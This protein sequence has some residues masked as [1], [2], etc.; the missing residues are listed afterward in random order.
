MRTISRREALRRV[1][2]AAALLSASPALANSYGPPRAPI[3]I[4]M[5]S[6][7][8]QWRAARQ[9]RHG[10]KFHDAPTFLE[11]AWFLGASGVQ[12]AIE[13]HDRAHARRI[14]YLANKFEM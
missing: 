6:Y 3:G 12:V 9:N 13:N 5:H 14:K 10:A 7:G 1:A 8:F 4:G 2:G 11:H